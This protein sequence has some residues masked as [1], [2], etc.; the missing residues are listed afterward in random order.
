[1]QF[2][3]GFLEQIARTNLIAHSCANE[4]A[5]AR[6]E[7]TIQSF[8][9]REVATLVL[10]HE[11]GERLSAFELGHVVA[12]RKNIRLDDTSRANWRITRCASNIDDEVI[13]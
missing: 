13:A 8:E 3:K 7:R 11:S 5:H 4:P 2:E 6:S 10:A 12:E 9:S 1:M